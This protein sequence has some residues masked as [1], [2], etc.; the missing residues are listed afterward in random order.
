MIV[1]REATSADLAAIAAMT[2]QRHSRSYAAEPNL[3]AA[4]ED[5]EVVRRALP[6]E[7]Q[8]WVLERDGE[9]TASLLWRDQ[10]GWAYCPMAGVV[11]DQW[12]IAMLYAV[13]AQ[14]WVDEGRTTHAIVVPSVD[15]AVSSRLIDL[16]F[17]R[18]QIHA[19]RTLRDG[20]GRQPAGGWPFTIEPVG[21]ERIDEIVALG[22]KLIRHHAGSPV[23]DVRSNEFFSGLEEAYREALETGTQTWIAY[24]KGQPVGLLLWRPGAPNESFSPKAAEIALLAVDPDQRGRRIGPALCQTAMATMAKYGHTSV[25]LDWRSTNLEASRFWLS[26][27]FLPVAHRY[28]REISLSPYRD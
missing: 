4:F 21:L 12:D 28:V 17:G 7:P 8:G 13:G 22:D 1:I 23:F 10:D 26:L 5:P 15:R 20:G 25:L 6:D 11:G 24:D 27:G 2:A 19:V 14:H 18:Q 16:S 9:I 3:N